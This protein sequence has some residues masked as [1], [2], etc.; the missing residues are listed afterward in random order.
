MLLWI[1]G[2]YSKAMGVTLGIEGLIKIP[3]IIFG[4]KSCP[5]E[6]WHFGVAGDDLC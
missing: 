5:D 3:P 1:N 4:H 6:P 2:A